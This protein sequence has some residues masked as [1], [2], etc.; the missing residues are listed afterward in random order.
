MAPF[1]SF[2]MV[3]L[4]TKFLTADRVQTIQTGGLEPS[5]RDDSTYADTKITIKIKFDICLGLFY[6]L[7]MRDN[8]L[9][10]QGSTVMVSRSKTARRVRHPGD[11]SPTKTRR[12]FSPYKN[13]FT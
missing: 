4:W 5:T 13:V 6:S 10:P 1:M 11:G 7:P 12:D 9:L 8:V 2:H 3:P